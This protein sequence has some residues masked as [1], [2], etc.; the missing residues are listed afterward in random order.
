MQRDQFNQ[1]HQNNDTFYR[2]NVVNAHC[3]IGSE[4]LPDVGRKRHCAIVK[5]S[6]AYVENVSCL[7]HIAKDNILQPYITQKDFITSI[8]FPGGNPGYKL[9]NF[10]I[11][12]QQDY[13]S[14]QPVKVRLD[15]R[16]SVPAATNLIG[17]ALLLTKK[18]VPV[19]CDGQR[20]FDLV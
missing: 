20:Q 8:N 2:P 14:A 16:P 11:H 17:Y 15:F 19:S 7:R 3:I 18:L 12:H 4:K 9:Y 10:D 1:Q 5:N 13:S 6:Q